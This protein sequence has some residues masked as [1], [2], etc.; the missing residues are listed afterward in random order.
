MTNVKG[1]YAKI[2]AK[3]FIMYT[4]YLKHGECKNQGGMM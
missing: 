4:V 2:K 1:N 3:E